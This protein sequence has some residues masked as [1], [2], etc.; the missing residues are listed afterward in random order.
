M[1]DGRWRDAVDRRTEPFA[2]VVRRSGVTA[3][4]IT[5]LGL[6]L[7]AAAAVLIGWGRIGAGVTVGVAASLTDLLDGPVAKASGTKSQRGSF[8]DSVSDR[9]TDS[10]MLLGVAWYLDSTYGNHAAVLAMGILVA[11][12]LVSYERAKA[13]SLGLSAKGGL[14]ERAERLIAIGLGL[15]VRPLLFPM[16]WAVLV[17]TVLTALMRFRLVWTGASTEPLEPPS[18]PAEP[19]LRQRAWRQGRVDSRWRSWRER[20]VIRSS[21]RDSAG[22][23]L[24]RWRARR[25]AVMSSRA[26]RA[27]RAGRASRANGSDQ[28]QAGAGRGLRTWRHE[29]LSGKRSVTEALRRRV[30]GQS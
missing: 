7:A 18:V 17:L 15:V 27:S 6:V 28:Q 1:L 14:M 10:V 30:D 23:P 21:R 11:A 25:H 29:R 12:N 2:S 20:A 9:A 22:A 5:A 3:D 8:F 24:G 16:L 19:L 26:S 4:Q 13:E